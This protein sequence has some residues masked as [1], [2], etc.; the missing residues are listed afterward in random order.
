MKSL[1]L[2][3]T[4]VLLFSSCGYI[5]NELLFP[6]SCLRCS[7]IDDMGNVL[8]SKEG[9][10]GETHKMEDNCK[11]EAY[12]SNAKCECETYRIPKEEDQ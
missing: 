1:L 8:W 12:D 7:V 3:L 10:G 6:R 4:A 11:L 5:F 9:C 2:I